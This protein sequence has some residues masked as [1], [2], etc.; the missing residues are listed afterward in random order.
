M[1]E[2]GTSHT[3][4]LAASKAEKGDKKRAIYPHLFPLTDADF[5]VPASKIFFL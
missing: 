5:V 4:V 3:R 1:S 2:L